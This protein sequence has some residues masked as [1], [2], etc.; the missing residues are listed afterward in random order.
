MECIA[1]YEIQSDASIGLDDY[2]LRFKHPRGIF[3]ARLK[4]VV[5]KNRLTPFLLALQITFDSPSLQEAQDIG[6]EHL[7]DCMNMLSFATGASFTSHRTIVIIDGTPSSGMRGCLLW[8]ED[9]GHE[10]PEP[11]LDDGIAKTIEWL[12]Q[13]DAPPVVRRA[14]RW[15]RFGVNASQPEDQFQYFWFALEILAEYK[16]PAEK[17]AEKCPR[18][19]SPLYC[20]TCKEHPTH[21]LF[22]KQAIR[23][24][25]ESVDAEC[26]EEIISNLDEARNRLMH[27]ATLKEIEDRLPEP[28]EEI[29]DVLG[30]LVFEALL[31]Q[32]PKEENDKKIS[33]GM[34]TTYVH[35]KLTSVV[36]AE[37]VIPLDERREFSMGG[38]HGTTVTMGK[39]GPPQSAF[40][41]VIEM[42]PEQQQ[43]LGAL[44]KEKG[45]GQEMCQRIYK[46]VIDNNGKRLSLVLATDMSRIKEAINKKESGGWQDLFREI[47]TAKKPALYIKRD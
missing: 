7:V 12:L 27:G 19:K 4:N 42:T 3:K 37:T 1:N 14:L 35:R 44:T 40:P 17:V 15:Y 20:E 6:K 8:P 22:V 9:A 13:Y 24:L 36:H 11:F 5:R 16:K 2:E 38:L 26:T 29:V 28:R 25:I 30:R 47:I 45:E 33:F 43:R 39:D 41:L 32:F 46:N 23:S 10:D 18:C 21:R 34:P 31:H